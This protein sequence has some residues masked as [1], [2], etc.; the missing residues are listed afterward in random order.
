[1]SGPLVCFSGMPLDPVELPRNETT[2]SRDPRKNKKSKSTDRQKVICNVVSHHSCS[3]P[4]CVLGAIV[5]FGFDPRQ[6]EPHSNEFETQLVGPDQFLDQ[7]VFAYKCAFKICDIP[8][9]MLVRYRTA[10]YAGIEIRM[11]LYLSLIHI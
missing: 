7:P 2:T 8:W 10:E 9:S 5:E 1:M 11:S 4:A 3:D 6:S